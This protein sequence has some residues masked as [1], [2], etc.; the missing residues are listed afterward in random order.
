MLR[1]IVGLIIGIFI[2]MKILDF[3]NKAF[4][5]KVVRIYYRD[6][7]R[8]KAL[9]QHLTSKQYIAPIEVP[10]MKTQNSGSDN[11]PKQDI[12]KVT[13]TV[14]RNCTQSKK[15]SQN[16]EETALEVDS[17]WNENDIPPEKEVFTQ[18]DWDDNLIPPEKEDDADLSQELNVLDKEVK[19]DFSEVKAEKVSESK[20]DWKKK[21]EEAIDKMLN[22]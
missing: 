3:R 1:S 2:F 5:R 22:F 12:K 19:E 13:N 6:Q 8:R 15:K 11:T 18:S 7:N 20:E 9:E 16:V 14:Q 4:K 21:N 10:P 17:T